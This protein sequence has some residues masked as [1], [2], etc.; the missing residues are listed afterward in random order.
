MSPLLGRKGGQQS[1]LLLM[2]GLP[3]LSC[4]VEKEG[5]GQRAKERT[6]Y[7]PVDGVLPTALCHHA[8]VVLF[9]DGKEFLLE[10][11]QKRGVGS[12]KAYPLA[13]TF[14]KY[15]PEFMFNREYFWQNRGSKFTT[16]Y[17]SEK[18]VKMSRYRI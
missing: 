13:A 5:D 1:S 2:R 3:V 18:W 10:A 15:H 12:L 9:A 4:R 7:P 6:H 16:N 11:T 14:T 17:S 8:W